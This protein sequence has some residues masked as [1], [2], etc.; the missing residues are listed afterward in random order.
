MGVVY[1]EVLKRG[2]FSWQQM[3]CSTWQKGGP[4]HTCRTA[5]E[6][7][8]TKATCATQL[9]SLCSARSP[10]HAGRAMMYQ[11]TG[12]EGGSRFRSRFRGDLLTT[13]FFPPPCLT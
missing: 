12:D 5:P 8:V 6:P 1:E 9:R 2:K 3:W 13:V 7:L 10:Q 4:S 11:F